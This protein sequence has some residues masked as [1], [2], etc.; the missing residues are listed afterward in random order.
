MTSFSIKEGFGWN[1]L[2]T[3][4]LELSKPSHPQVFINLSEK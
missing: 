2:D 4:G 1:H 3:F